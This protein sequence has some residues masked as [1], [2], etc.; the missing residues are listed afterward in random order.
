MHS[1][2]QLLKWVYACKSP[3]VKM[4]LCKILTTITKGRKK[5]WDIVYPIGSIKILMFPP[6]FKLMGHF[7]LVFLGMDLRCAKNKVI[8]YI[9]LIFFKFSIH[10]YIIFSTIFKRYKIFYI[11]LFLAHLKI[12]AKNPHEKVEL[13]A[14]SNYITNPKPSCMS[15][16]YLGLSS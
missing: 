15:Y 13:D 8:H 16:N 11:I 4:S 7:V 1:S 12:P 3:I 5:L 10:L 6:P 2:L 14:G 9:Y